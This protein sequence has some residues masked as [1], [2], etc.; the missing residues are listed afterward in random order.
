MCYLGFFLSVTNILYYKEKLQEQHSQSTYIGKQWYKSI[1]PKKKT[2]GD[3][4]E[5]NVRRRMI[6]AL[7]GQRV[8]H[9]IGQA[10]NMFKFHLNRRRQH[11]DFIKREMKLP[12]TQP[13]D[14]T[15]AI[16]LDEL[17]FKIN[18]IIKH[19]HPKSL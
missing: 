17:L 2:K 12:R 1:I 13:N 6:D 15:Q 4:K 9:S 3:Y 5:N 18:S 14:E 16:A 8:F 7:L 10:H 19:N 11:L